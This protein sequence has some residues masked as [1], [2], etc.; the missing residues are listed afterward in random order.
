M[1]RGTV[2][3]VH[4]QLVRMCGAFL[5]GGGPGGGGGGGIYDLVVLLRIVDFV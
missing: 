1:K 4:P 3:E 2:V 5:P